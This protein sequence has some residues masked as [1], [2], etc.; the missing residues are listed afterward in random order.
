MNIVEQFRLFGQDA[1]NLVRA[2]ADLI[3][4]EAGEKLQQ[5]QRGLIA[6]VGGMLCLVVA[7]LVLIQSLIDWL[8]V[9]IGEPWSSLLV[10]VIIALIGIGLYLSG[11]KQLTAENLT[12]HRSMAAARR[13][14]D[15]VRDLV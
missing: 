3:R 14:A 6:I 12:M 1:A 9:V 7:G 2:E 4:A 11:R 8:A 5:A 15:M 10:G 13:S